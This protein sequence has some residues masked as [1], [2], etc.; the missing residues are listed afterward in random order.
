LRT[1]AP[2]QIDFLR[3]GKRRIASGDLQDMI[4]VILAH[5][6][7]PGDDYEYLEVENIC[8]QLNWLK[9]L[10][11]NECVIIV[12]AVETIEEIRLVFVAQASGIILI[13]AVIV[14]R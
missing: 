8:V 9:N 13:S 7:Q 6:K 2:G 10:K 12:M 5:A 3:K 14:S 4:R 11:R 1:K